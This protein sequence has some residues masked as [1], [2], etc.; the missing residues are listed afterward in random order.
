M[1][2]Q[3]NTNTCLMERTQLE[4]Q[5]YLLHKLLREIM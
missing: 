1:E 4:L 3:A 2:N 5:A